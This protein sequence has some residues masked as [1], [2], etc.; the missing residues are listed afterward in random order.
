MLAR[1]LQ[2]RWPMRLAVLMLWSASAMLAADE[3]QLALTLRGQ[4]DFDRVKLA[5]VPQLADAYTCIQSQAALLPVASRFDLPLVRYRKGFCA[6]IL[7]SMTRKAGDFTNAAADLDA[8]V[9][10]WPGRIDKPPKGMVVEPVSSAL[11]LLSAIARLN[12][13]PDS[14]GTDA[15]VKAIGE[16]EARPDCPASVMPVAECQGILQIGRQWLGWIAFRENRLAEAGREFSGEGW[17]ELVAA[18]LAFEKRNFAQAAK[19]Y[20]QAIQ[21]W[22]RLAPSLS[23]RLG[24]RPDIAGALTDLGGAQLLAGQAAAAIATL[25]SAIKRDPAHAFSYFL[26]ARAKEATGQTDAALTDYNLASRVSFAGAKDL[27][28]GEAHLYRG[29]LLYRRK[30]YAR[31]EDEFIS[32]LNFEIPAGM[33]ADAVAWRNLAA[34]AGGACAAAREQLQKAMA[35][36]SPYFP[37]REA[38]SLMRACPGAN[39]ALQ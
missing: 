13:G 27:V 15:G 12:T 10:A 24:P 19:E 6:L 9:A 32:A 16:A 30:D 25:D 18:R 14:A 22:E 5:A 33:R 7:A 37:A 26:R 29:V 21:T 36:T 4:S 17:P 38:Q 39:G 23:V 35:S 28:S 3:A 20:Q 8:A 1:D 31:A 11:P 2:F 34:V